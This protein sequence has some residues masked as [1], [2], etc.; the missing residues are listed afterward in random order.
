MATGGQRAGG[1]R[2]A[3]VGL[4]LG[5]LGLGEVTLAAGERGG[6]GRRAGGGEVE[7]VDRASGVLPLAADRA[8]GRPVDDH[9]EPDP[10]ARLRTHRGALVGRR[11]IGVLDPV[12]AMQERHR[13]LILGECGDQDQNHAVRPEQRGRDRTP[14]LQ[15]LVPVLGVQQ[16]VGDLFGQVAPASRA[17]H[18]PSQVRLRTDAVAR[19]QEVPAEQA[20]Q[21]RPLAT[22]VEH[23]GGEPVHA[24]GDIEVTND[25]VERRIRERG[26]HRHQA[27]R[28]H[29]R[30]QRRVDRL[31]AEPLRQVRRPRVGRPAAG[32]ATLQRRAADPLGRRARTGGAVLVERAARH[33]REQAGAY[34]GLGGG[35][36][37]LD[38]LLPPVV[39]GQVADRDEVVG[40]QVDRV[41][42]T[43][44]RDAMTS[45]VG[46]SSPQ[47]HAVAV[48]L[49]VPPRVR[50]VGAV[51]REPG[52]QHVARRYRP[53]GG[54]RGDDRRDP[55]GTI[56]ERAGHPVV[57][58]LRRRGVA[59]PGHPLGD[60]GAI[61]Q[62]CVA[63]V[64]GER[65]RGRVRATGVLVRR[66]HAVAAV[67]KICERGRVERA[68]GGHDS[69][70]VS[71]SSGR[72]CPA[73]VH[74]CRG[75]RWTRGGRCRG[76]PD[77][78]GTGWTQPASSASICFAASSNACV[79]V[80]RPAA[81]SVSWA[82]MMSTIWFCLSP[83]VG[84][85]ATFSSESNTA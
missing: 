33:G 55:V 64:R 6:V 43:V 80:I 25:R 40:G 45:G 37:V 68:G 81:A 22:A 3:A 30:G 71:W 21:Q 14:A 4:E 77:R 5:G 38:V 42:P 24:A 29:A 17:G 60:E 41:A 78:P 72:A 79:A 54:T 44:Q 23:V 61:P 47:P 18:R 35:V 65:G 69:P 66:D 9:A 46:D 19:G 31:G 73:R 50:P 8:D 11:R 1:H 15:P 56:D 13:A 75:T 27:E 52:R 2:P 39:A 10:L 53:A 84:G 59:E 85:S 16:V 49:E 51:E 76:G 28:H 32:H 34:G 20:G 67:G 7:H 62:P 26:T 36:H 74:R 70:L 57:K 82:L 48:G 58:R 83:T 12:R 63:A